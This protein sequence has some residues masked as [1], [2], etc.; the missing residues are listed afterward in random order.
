MSASPC[1][2]P[3]MEE[4]PVAS[5]PPCASGVVTSVPACVLPGTPCVRGA[6][7]AEETT[8]AAVTARVC[9]PPCVSEAPRVSA[10]AGV[11]GVVCVSDRV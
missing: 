11:R 1:A 2:T 4:T 6:P 7:Q 10:P 3:G 8:C 5:E 9:E